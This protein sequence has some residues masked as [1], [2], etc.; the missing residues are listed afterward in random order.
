[1]LVRNLIPTSQ[2]PAYRFSLVSCSF[3]ICD[4]KMKTGTL[5]TSQSH[6]EVALILDWGGVLE[7]LE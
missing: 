2:T 3:F 5:S 1:M 4:N 6:Y 7:I